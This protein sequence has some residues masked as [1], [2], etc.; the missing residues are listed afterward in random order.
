[1]ANVARSVNDLLSFAKEVVRGHQ[2]Q[3]DTTFLTRYHRETDR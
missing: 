1:M 3:P 2:W